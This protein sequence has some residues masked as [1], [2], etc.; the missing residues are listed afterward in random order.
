MRKYD[1]VEETKDNLTFKEFV[2]DE[3]RNK[4]PIP[5]WWENQV[6]S[7]LPRGAIGKF[8]SSLNSA[9]TNYK[10]G[11]NSKFQMKFRTKKSP[12]DYLNFEDKGYPKF[13]RD[14]K[15]RYWFTTRDR[16]RSFVS[17]S[18]IDSQ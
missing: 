15:S 5:E 3:D 16:K 11:N 1:Y 2:F 12:T 10:N 6:H 14:I 17:F 18:E 9:I 7:R 13:I 4:I 8:V